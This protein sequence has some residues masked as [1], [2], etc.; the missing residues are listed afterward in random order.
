VRALEGPIAPMV[1]AS[2]DPAHA[3]LCGRTGYCNVNTLW[4]RV[5]DAIVAALDSMTLADLA[6][7]TA[8]HP[9]HPLTPVPSAAPRDKEPLPTA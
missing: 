8:S 2:E 5:R 7:P 1:C 9:F 3:G 4:V 6:R